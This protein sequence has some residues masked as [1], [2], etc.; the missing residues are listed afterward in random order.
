MSII[1]EAIKK[2][3]KESGLKEVKDVKIDMGIAGEGTTIAPPA[4][5]SETKWTFM[6]ILSLIITLSFLGSIL[7]Y[8]NLSR[9]A[10]EYK[11]VTQA[12]ASVKPAAVQLPLPQPSLPALKA[13]DTI[14]L[15]GIVYGPDEKWAVINDKIIR[16]G[17]SIP[18][19]KLSLIEKDFVKV[20][21]NNGEEL[22]LNLR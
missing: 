13:E 6:A 3:R 15:N 11:P 17:E 5:P 7:L 4:E 10:V 14:K 8:K 2:A 1:N 18:G 22:I 21:K 12:P 20:V 9:P 16:E 19:G